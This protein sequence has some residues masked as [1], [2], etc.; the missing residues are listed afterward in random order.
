MK[1]STLIIEGSR[2]TD[3]AFGLYIAFDLPRNKTCAL[4]AAQYAWHV[5]H[6][7]PA[8]EMLSEFYSTLRD[9]Y[10][11]SPCS[12]YALRGNIYDIITHLNDVHRW[13]REAIALWVE[14]VEPKIEEASD[15]NGEK[16]LPSCRVLLLPVLAGVE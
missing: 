5:V 10:D 12:C 7:R 15:A 11:V 8:S 2:L 3:Q 6:G 13:S 4:G 1:L 14:Q 9:Y 16:E